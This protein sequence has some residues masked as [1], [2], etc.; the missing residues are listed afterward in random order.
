M[1]RKKGQIVLEMWSYIFPAF[2][3]LN[4]TSR[5]EISFFNYT[6]RTTLHHFLW[7][8]PETIYLHW[9]TFSTHLCKNLLA[10]QKRWSRT[11]VN[12]KRSRQPLNS[13]GF[14]I[15]NLVDGMFNVLLACTG[16]SLT[17]S[18]WKLLSEEKKSISFIWT[19]SLSF[20]HKSNGFR[21]QWNWVHSL[22]R[23]AFKSDLFSFNLYRES[24]R[25]Y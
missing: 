5:N 7:S 12:R 1:H 22:H 18:T 3:V 9:R 8:V 24:R 11:H 17:P 13:A 16:V 4:D 14:I 10:M 6:M 21:D 15:K 2:P 19:E 23:G 25:Y 20:M